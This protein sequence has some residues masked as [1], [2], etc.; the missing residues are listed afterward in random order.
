MSKKLIFGSMVAAG[1]V[2]LLSTLD[3]ALKVPFA[4]YSPTMDI[5][6]LV[7]AAIILFMCWESYRENR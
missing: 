4:G 6:Y 3:L 1:L 5:L 2:A 7:A